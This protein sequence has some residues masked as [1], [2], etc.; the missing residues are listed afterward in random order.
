MSYIQVNS[1]GMVLMAVGLMA[2]RGVSRAVNEW[3]T[4]W[5]YNR[6]WSSITVSVCLFGCRLALMRIPLLYIP[7]FSDNSALITN[8]HL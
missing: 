8:G 3:T 7:N 5:G 6:L 1:S 4:K 2:S